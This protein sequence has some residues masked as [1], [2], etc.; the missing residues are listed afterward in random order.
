[1]LNCQFRIQSSAN[2]FEN[3]ETPKNKIGTGWYPLVNGETPKNL[4]GTGWYPLVKEEN[5]T[6]IKGKINFGW[7]VAGIVKGLAFKGGKGLSQFLGKLQIL[8]KKVKLQSGS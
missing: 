7:F 1:M 6:E 8:L 4:I 5:V 3:G 2:A